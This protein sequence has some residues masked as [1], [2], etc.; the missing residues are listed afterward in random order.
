MGASLLAALTALGARI[1][2]RLPGTP[3]P[4]T[5][6]VLAVLLPQAVAFLLKVLLVLHQALPALLLL[7]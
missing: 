4:M 1:A 5:L 3:V 7:V 2:L 6:Q